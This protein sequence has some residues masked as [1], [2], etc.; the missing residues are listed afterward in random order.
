LH[1]S[2][3]VER[4][5]FGWICAILI[6]LGISSDA[7]SAPLR[8][9][10]DA[11]PYRHQEA[12]EIAAQLKAIGVQVTVRIWE[13]ADLRTALK[14][15]DRTAALTDWGSAF[16][17]PFDLAGPKLISR[18]RGNFSFYSN[19][20]VDR[21]LALAASTA[22]VI[23]R[24]NAY[25]QTQELIYRQV[26]WSFGYTMTNIE[27]VSST[28]LNYRS[29]MDSRISLHD[30]GLTRGDV[31]VVGMNTNAF[32]TL[33]PAMYRDRETESVIHN[34]YDGLVTRTPTGAVVPQLAESWEFHDDT[35]CEFILRQGP[36]FHNGEPVTAADVLFTFNR[37]LQP[38]AIGGKSSP[39]RALLG[40]L[41]KV[42]QTGPRQVRFILEKPLAAFLQALVHFQIV[43][44]NY[45]RN[46]GD[47]ALHDNPVGSGPFRFISGRL[48]KEVVLER[49]DEY[50]GGAP[51][52]MPV[53]PAPVKN[54]V[55]K[56]MPDPTTR[57]AALLAGEAS[58]IQALPVDFVQLLSNR[59]TVKVSAVEGTRS[60]QLELNNDRAP[61]NDERV[62]LAMNCGINWEKILKNVYG[63]HGDRLATCFLPSGF[64]HNPYLRPHP[65]DPEKAKTLLKKAGYTP[66]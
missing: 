41:L 29:A 42:E 33:D 53:G 51:F 12:L 52:L 11:P 38:N 19:P 63:G 27:A 25:Y 54:V 34:I 20:R 1:Q 10:L 40:S 28:V 58:I 14:T 65:Y 50:Y 8:F 6:I 26:P 3:R 49:F 46:K 39:R 32:Y 4:T 5:A 15:G 9:I 56:T 24:K 43:P 62:R 16:F 23:E 66:D 21:L 13:K 45:V 36:I 37:V 48:D 7:Q 22:D 55:F 47:A 30:V 61:F 57:V 31:L 35:I 2:N 64:G 44:R 59:R 18:G 17:D 60:Y